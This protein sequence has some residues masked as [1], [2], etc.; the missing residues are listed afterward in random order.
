M[1]RRAVVV[2]TVIGSRMGVAIE[3]DFAASNEEAEAWAFAAVIFDRR[4]RREQAKAEEA[5]RDKP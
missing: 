5:A 4:E 3:P 1:S 2:G